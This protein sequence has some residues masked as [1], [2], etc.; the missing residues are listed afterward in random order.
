MSSI[1]IENRKMETRQSD[2][3]KTGLKIALT[4]LVIAS[5]F[6]AFSSVGFNRAVSPVQQLLQDRPTKP[7]VEGEDNDIS[8][9]PPIT[10]IATI[11]KDVYTASLFT[12]CRSSYD[13]LPFFG[14]DASTLLQYSHL[15]D[16]TAIVEPHI[17]MKFAILDDDLPDDNYYK[18]SLCESSDD[19]ESC[20]EGKYFPDDSDSSTGV[21][22]KCTPFTS[23]TF[24]IEVYGS[25]DELISTLS[26]KAL[27][28]YVRREIRSLSTKDLQKTMDAM[29]T[30]W[31]TR[32]GRKSNSTLNFNHYF[33][34][35]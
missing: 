30:L 27:C 15:S 34:D 2:F 17:T 22:T 26:S 5:I 32:S 13:P 16:Y 28:M 11:S 8:H 1:K 12:L 14:S 21:K 9:S 31:N 6:L 20:V 19:E 7:S 18:F 23:Y 4:C 29:F 24:N 3:H 35:Q 25:D 10:K 33:A